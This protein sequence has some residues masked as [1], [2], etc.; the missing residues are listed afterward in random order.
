MG[1][2]SDF[3]NEQINICLKEISDVESELR[4][5]DVAIRDSYKSEE[6]INDKLSNSDSV[7]NVDTYELNSGEPGIEDIQ[8]ERNLLLDSRK[9]LETNLMDL[10]DKL[11]H[12]RS[13]YTDSLKSKRGTKSTKEFLEFI[14]KL[15]DTD[16]VRAKLEISNYL[17]EDK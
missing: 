5:I 17:Q 4:E 16:P 7:F 10:Q 9:E 8:N 12:L 6:S 1:K 3:F 11:N 14:L 13:L 2:S 15:I